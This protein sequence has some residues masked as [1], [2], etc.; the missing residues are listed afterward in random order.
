MSQVLLVTPKFTVER[1]QVRRPDGTVRIH[2]LVTHPGAVV[3]L[4]ILD[5]GSIVLIRNWRPSVGRELLE[6]PAGTLEPGEPP[7]TC[8]RRELEEETG[9]RAANVT[10]VAEFYT[11]PGI[12]TERMHGFVARGLTATSQQLDAG[13]HIR[14]EVTP[15]D[16]VLHLLSCG[17]F[18]DGKSI[19]MLSLHF[20]QHR[21]PSAKDGAGEHTRPGPPLGVGGPDR[22]E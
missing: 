2:D 11:S 20:L 17:S 9:Y 1:R 14:V 13:E 16:K 5:D 12:C 21:T 3:V 6:L 7:E 22:G 19:A 4:P 15:A 8:A 10:A 18:E